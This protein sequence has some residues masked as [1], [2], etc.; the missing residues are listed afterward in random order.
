MLIYNASF[1]IQC[2]LLAVLSLLVP[3]FAQADYIEMLPEIRS[4]IDKESNTVT[5]DIK[6]TN[7]GDAISEE[8]SIEFPYLKKSFFLAESLKPSESATFRTSFSFKELGINQNGRYYIPARIHY[9]DGLYYA[10]SSP[11]L[12]KLNL[13]PLGLEPLIMTFRNHI[14]PP[15]IEMSEEA[16][17]T[18]ELSNPKP[19]PV[20]ITEIGIFGSNEIFYQI[21]GASFPLELGSREKKELS[22]KAKNINGIK[23]SSYVA[24]VLANTS[25]E[26]AHMDSTVYFRV[27]IVPKDSMIYYAVAG[28]AALTLLLIAYFF[29][30]K[31]I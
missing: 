9:K 27:G 19:E 3:A 7:G 2:A 14:G 26:I 30:K 31:K 5:F 13:K 1:S 23:N 6:I 17:F 29:R 10:F 8:V 15:N 11:H 22:I 28:V 4:N 21:D 25:D 16:R 12:V 20:E 24:F 18:L